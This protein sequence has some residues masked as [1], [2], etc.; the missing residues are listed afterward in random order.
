[1]TLGEKLRQR[2]Q[3]PIFHFAS[4]EI[5][6][7]PRAVLPEDPLH[8][9]ARSPELEIAA[10]AQLAAFAVLEALDAHAKTL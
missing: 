3:R 5:E 1:M 6:H 10:D 4:A 2:R 7:H 8:E 9:L